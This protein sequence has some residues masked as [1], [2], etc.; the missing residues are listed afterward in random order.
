MIQSWELDTATLPSLTYGHI[1]FQNV[2]M[3][4]LMKVLSHHG[5]SRCL[6]NQKR[7]V[8]ESIYVK[9]EWPSLNRGG[10]LWHNLTPTY[11]AGLSSLSRQLNNHSWAHLALANN[12][13]AGLTNDP[14]VALMTLTLRAHVSLNNS[15]RTLPQFQSLR[16]HAWSLLDERW[17]VLNKLKQIQLH[18]IQHLDK[19]VNIFKVPYYT[20]V[21][22]FDTAVRGLKTLYSICI[23]PNPCMVLNFSCLKLALQSSIQSSLILCQTHQTCFK[24]HCIVDQSRAN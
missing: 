10:G 9:L 7:G 4:M 18:T 17:D 3:S 6:L 20:V 2:S 22:Q 14:Q 21:H 8:K 19:H 15:V 5:Q 13:K 12:M 23:T 16:L 11:N 1:L 24:R